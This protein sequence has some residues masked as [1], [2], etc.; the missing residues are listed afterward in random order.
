MWLFLQEA[1]DTKLIEA[2]IFTSL[3]GTG[4]AVLTSSYR[5]FLVNSVKE[6][7]V[8]RLAE[9]P[10]KCFAWVHMTWNFGISKSAVQYEKHQTKW[11]TLSFTSRE[12]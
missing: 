5:I 7:K 10:S 1:K 2:K 11:H 9:V 4:V 12:V 8:R 3:S 6:P